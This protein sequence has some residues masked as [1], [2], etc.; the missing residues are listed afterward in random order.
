[1]KRE[2]L[3]T[4]SISTALKE[5]PG[6]ESDGACLRKEFSFGSYLA[7]IRFVQEV[8]EAAEA[9]N[10]H[11][12]LLVRWRKVAVTLSTHSAGGITELDSALARQ[13]EQL[14]E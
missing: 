9:M 3:D 12:D 11:P 7:G 13:I 6:W 2:L 1:M 14:A 5:L 4:E 10:H 8:A